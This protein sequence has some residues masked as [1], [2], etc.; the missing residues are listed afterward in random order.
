M[1][2]VNRGHGLDEPAASALL[3]PLARGAPDGAGDDIGS[4]G[5]GLFIVR[6][7]ARA[8]RGEVEVRSAAG[9]TTF[10]VR[11]PKCMETTASC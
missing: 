4:L 6:E 7:I 3:Q 8:H 9:Q 10:V 1:R 11:L 2:V 5:L